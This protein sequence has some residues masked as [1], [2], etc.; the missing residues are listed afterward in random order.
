VSEFSW[1]GSLASFI[2]QRNSKP[3]FSIPSGEI[4]ESVGI[5]KERCVSLPLVTHSAPP[6]PNCARAG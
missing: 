4:F 3:G 1:T 6:R 5:E 2:F